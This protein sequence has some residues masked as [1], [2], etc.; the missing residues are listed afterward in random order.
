V[1]PDEARVRFATA[2]VARL[3]T[4]DSTGRPHLVPIVFTLD[5]DVLYSAVDHKPKRTVALR[6][7]ANVAANPA[8]SVLVDHYDDGDWDRLWWVRADGVGAV[9]ASNGA[10]AARARAL[11]QER[12]PQYVTRPLTGQVLA[13]AVERWS[14][15][16]ADGS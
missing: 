9:L 1:S 13:I 16:A 7:L 3:G 5:G 12:Y 10:P 6:R 14:G 11:L 8:V 4:V 15:W 2:R